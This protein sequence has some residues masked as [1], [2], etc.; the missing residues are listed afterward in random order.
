MVMKTKLS[1]ISFTVLMLWI[2]AAEKETAPAAGLIAEIQSKKVQ[3]V[4]VLFTPDGLVTRSEVNEKSLEQ[5]SSQTVT[6]TKLTQNKATPLLLK[7]L[8]GVNNNTTNQNLDFRR[9]CKF[10][11]IQGHKIHRLYINCIP[12]FGSLDGKPVTFSTNMINWIYAVKEQRN[13]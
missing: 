13:K 11:D 6:V 2:G 8:Q 12:S 10:Y 5:I 4:D 7:D 3:R 1:I 9:G